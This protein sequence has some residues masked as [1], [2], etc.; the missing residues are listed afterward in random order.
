LQE[1]FAQA[2]SGFTWLAE[3]S[4]PLSLSIG[5]S[6]FPEDAAQHERLIAAADQATFLAKLVGG[7]TALRYDRWPERLESDPVKLRALLKGANPEALQAVA[8]AIDARDSFNRGHCR[9]VSQHAVGIAREMG[10]DEA[11]VERLRIAALLHDLGKIGV[12]EAVLTKP[13]PLSPR[14]QQEV[15][16]HV[17]VGVDLLGGIDFLQ[18]KLAI[19]GSHHENF[20]G[21]GYP[22]RL[23]GQEIPLGGRI[24]RVADTFEAM[25]RERRY[26]KGW[27]EE[28][29]LAEIEQLSGRH[30]DPKVASALASSLRK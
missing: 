2:L 30:F 4:R 26:R 14:E 19:I 24:L 20:D 16:G 29:A 3:L 6:T 13:G 18:D 8:T 9:R 15:Q 17:G 1:G 5:V 22:N 21:S 7:D 12:A 28:E 27:T 23:A 25:T 10:M 11:E